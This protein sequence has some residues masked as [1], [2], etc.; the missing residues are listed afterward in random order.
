MNEF[1]NEELERI[2]KIGNDLILELFN[3][4]DKRHVIHKY[5]RFAY[6][7]GRKGERNKH[8][9]EKESSIIEISEKYVCGD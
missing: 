7:Q 8:K 6:L 9:A 5:I 2:E 3:T 1:S 4:T